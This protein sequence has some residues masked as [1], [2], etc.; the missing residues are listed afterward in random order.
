MFSERSQRTSITVVVIKQLLHGGREKFRLLGRT[1]AAAAAAAAAGWCPLRRPRH[2]THTVCDSI[3][4]CVVVHC[5]QGGQH[6]PKFFS[7]KHPCSQKGNPD[8][9]SV[10]WATLQMHTL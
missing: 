2:P 3:G 5:W 8:R 4:V 1:A 7:L 10:D 9:T 6:M